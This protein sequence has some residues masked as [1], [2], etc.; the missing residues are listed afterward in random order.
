M[1]DQF[2]PYAELFA[3]PKGPGDARPKASQIIQDNDLIGKWTGKVVLVT[4]GTSGIGMETARALHATGADVYITARSFK[5]AET[6]IAD[7]SESS[8]GS[9]KID[10]VEMDMNSLASVKKAAQS[11]LARSKTLNILVNNAG[12][13]ATPEGSK[14]KD[15]FEQQFGVNH[16]AHFTLTA[17]LLPTLISSSTP[18]FNSRVVALSSSGHRFS[19]VHLDD[20]NLTNLTNLTKDLIPWIGYGQSKTANIW[21]ANYIDRVYGPRG[22]HAISVHP[23]VVMT[24]LSQNM[25]AEAVEKWM[26]DAK[27]MAVLLSPDQGAATTTWAAVAG[28]WEGKGGKYLAECSVAVPAKDLLAITETGYAPHAYNVEGENGL[29]ALSERLTG[30]KV[31]AQ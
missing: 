21:L 22:V 9:G 29:W 5:K 26:N 19:T 15:G 2:N 30:V 14:T 24:N 25:S 31:Q 16:L 8:E 6:V 1:S 20:P 28:D 3:S 10:F 23:G 13:M 27:F 11:F 4:G 17:L 12:I 7:I 18:S